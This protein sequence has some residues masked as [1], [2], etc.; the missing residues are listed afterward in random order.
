MAGVKWNVRTLEVR[1]DKAERKIL[2]ACATHYMRA[3]KDTI[4]ITA[5]G[6]SRRARAIRRTRGNVRAGPLRAIYD[7]VIK[8]GYTP[9][10][11]A[12]EASA[13][14]EKYRHSKPGEPPRKITGFLQRNVVWRFA[15]DGGRL[16]ARAGLFTNAI[17]GFFLEV[18]FRTRRRTG[19]GVYRV[20]PRPWM[21]RTLREEVPN[22]KAIAER[23]TPQG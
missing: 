1:V 12:K 18:G 16:V 11:A 10:E 4:A 22:L 8:H 2:S 5:G 23:Y 9:R 7:L 3:A 21:G 17:Y 20:L 13:E 19:R 15:T 14:Y 6:N